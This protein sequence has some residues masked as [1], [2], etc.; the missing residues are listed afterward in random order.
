MKWIIHYDVV[1]FFLILIILVVYSSYH[2]L[3]TFVNKVYT[4]L[5]IVSL[6]SVVTDIVTAYTCSFCTK[7][8]I[9]LNYVANLIHFLVQNAVPCLYTLFAHALIYETERIG[10]KWFC[11]IF[12]PY[13]FSDLIMSKSFMMQEQF[14]LFEFFL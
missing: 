7:D 8:Q 4:R 3:K 11:I 9:V 13:I 14:F 10:K 1:A 2:R 12:L 5:L 6:C